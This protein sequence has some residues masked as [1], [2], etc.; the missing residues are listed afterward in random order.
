MSM[1]RYFFHVID[2]QMLLDEHGTECATLADMRDQAIETA[3]AILRDMGGNFP[4]GVEWQMH[5]TDEAKK[6]VLRLRFSA[7]G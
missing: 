6:T 5:V 3:G 2:G 7:D 1:A 4:T